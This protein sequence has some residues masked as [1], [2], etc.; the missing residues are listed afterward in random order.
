ML[1]PFS[2]HE[3]LD[4]LF[5]CY[6]N[7]FF[8]FYFLITNCYSNKLLQGNIRFQMHLRISMNYVPQVTYD[9]SEHTKSL[10]FCNLQIKLKDSSQ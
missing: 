5:N 4:Y 9:V 1:E 10:D 2:D 7:E 6:A 8:L 3:V